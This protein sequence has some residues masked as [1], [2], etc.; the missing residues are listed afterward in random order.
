MNLNEALL[1]ELKH[2]AVNT[3]KIL[4]R[5]PADKYNW[6]PHEK[7]MSLGQLTSHLA[8]LTSWLNAIIEHP[9]LDFATY[10]YKPKQFS[11]T[12]D[13][14]KFYDETLA[15]GSGALQAATNETLM[16]NWKLRNS[17]RVF[18]DL[19]RIAVVR[20]MVLSHVIHHRGQLSVY[21]RLLDVPL[22][23]IY[24]PTA[25]ESM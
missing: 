6:K 18:L 9:E 14:L 22:P 15:K 10:D 17:D 11:T 12:E 16:G 24:G 7:S 25:D 21:L 8:E 20:T 19:P 5:A 13:L 3:R 23:S 1:A 4:E 2:E